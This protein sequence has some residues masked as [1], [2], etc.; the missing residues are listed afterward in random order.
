MSKTKNF[1]LDTEPKPELDSQTAM[2]NNITSNKEV[3]FLHGDLELKI[4]EAENLPNMDVISEHF[5]RCIIDYDTVKFRSAFDYAREQ[6]ARSTTIRRLSPV[7]LTL[8]LL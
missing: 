5:Y 8:P 4:I 7:T 1:T 3:I 2:A 6:T